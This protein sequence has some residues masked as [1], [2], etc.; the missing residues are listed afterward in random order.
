[1]TAS[2]AR[3]RDD[4]E[5]AAV[6]AADALADLSAE[7]E[8]RGPWCGSVP[9]GR[10]G[11]LR[12][13]AAPVWV[14]TVTGLVDAGGLDR[15]RGR[16]VSRGYLHRLVAE[17]AAAADQPTGRNCMPGHEELGAVLGRPTKAAKLAAMTLMTPAARAR[18][19]ARIERDR[20]RQV[21]NA[22][23]VLKA[24]GLLVCVE[25]GRMLSCT[26]RLEL[27]ANGVDRRYARAV[28]ALTLPRTTPTT[29]PAVDNPAGNPA[30]SDPVFG[31]PRSGK[32]GTYPSDSLEV[33]PSFQQKN[34]RSTADC[35]P[36][37]AGG[38]PRLP[39]EHPEQ[40]AAAR[41]PAPKRRRS[42]WELTAEQ[43]R[44]L[45]D[46][47]AALPGQ[48]RGAS[49]R[50]LAGCTNRFWLLG[51]DAASVAAA[52]LEVYERARRPLPGYRPGNPAAWLGWVLR[53][54]DHTLSPAVR[55]YADWA[56]AADTEEC[57]HRQPGGAR[58]SVLTGQPK[59]P[60]CR[61]AAPTDQQ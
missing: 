32:E 26:E 39:A 17:L 20:A 27:Y 24:A 37:A 36:T 1:V 6:A 45:I 18:T 7:L 22:V 55:R 15:L 61:H 10:Y 48:L 30:P 42:L 34:S 53:Q 28:Y 9:A 23:N 52:V 14:A 47:R 57:P 29:S 21:T 46:L 60:L 50:R 25:D 12:V 3:L 43:Y 54:V 51:W 33:F 31:P 40:A 58:I 16:T 41:R 8:R 44:F 2:D 59:C 49:L 11:P 35:A 56:Q 4:V 38:E 19:Q 13:L 5:A